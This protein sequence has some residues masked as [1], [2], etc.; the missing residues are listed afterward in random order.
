MLDEERKKACAITG[1]RPSRFLFKND[2]EH[3]GCRKIKRSLKEQLLALYDS[4]VRR[5][6]LGGAN[7]VD[8]WAGE[9]LLELK[10]QGRNDIEMILALPFEGYDKKWS[11]QI[12]NR[13]TNLIRHSTETVMVGN[14]EKTP[15][16]SYRR[17]NEYMVDRS[18]SLLAVYD[19]NRA[20]RSGTG[21]TVRYAEKKA[22]LITLIHPDTSV[23]SQL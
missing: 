19:N 13:M 10:K 21:M 1:H 20:L 18:G 14:A 6:Y 8:L 9:I 23:V 11:E 15:A 3:D 5:F 17:R 7:G 4:G 12:R 22:L 2:E 16:A